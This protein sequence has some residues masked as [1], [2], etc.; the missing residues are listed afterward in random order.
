MQLTPVALAAK[1]AVD[2]IAADF[3]NFVFVLW[4]HLGLREPTPN[5]VRHRAVPAA[6]ARGAGSSRPS[7]A[8]VSRGSP[9][10]SCCGACAANPNERIL[11]VSA[12]EDRA[13][14]FT[15]F[16]RR[17]IATRPRS[18]STSPAQGPARLR[19][20]LRRGRLDGPPVAPPRAAGITGQITGGRASLIVADDVE[21]P[22][23]SLTQTMR[24]RLSEA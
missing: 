15:T 21:V 16:C 18:C 5:P 10:P 14:Q 13:L 24:D 6:R 17:L 11:V 9:R 22:K 20:R 8:W 4:K 23:N 1:E 12:N 3:R 2:P 19:L 7:G